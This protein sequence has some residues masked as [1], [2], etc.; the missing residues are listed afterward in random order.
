MP[1]LASPD[2]VETEAEASLDVYFIREALGQISQNCRRILELLH[3]QGK[4]YSEVS[5]EMGVSHGWIGPTRQRCLERLRKL[6]ES[7]GS[8]HSARK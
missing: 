2:L 3:L 4:S 5:A 1:D 7:L 8:R 6:V